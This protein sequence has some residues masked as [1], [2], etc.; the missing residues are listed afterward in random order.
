[1]YSVAMKHILILLLFSTFAF[2]KESV[3]RIEPENPSSLVNEERPN[4]NPLI[5]LVGLPVMTNQEQAIIDAEKRRLEKMEAKERAKE[6]KKLQRMAN[7]KNGGKEPP[8]ETLG[9]SGKK[10][11]K[12]KR[13]VTLGKIATEVYGNPAYATLVSV[14]NKKPANRLF[15][16]EKLK[17]PSPYKIYTALAG[18]KVWEKYPYAI[19]DCLLVHERFKKLEPIIL[20]ESKTKEGFS[21]V[22]KE[23]LDDMIW[24]VDQ[25]KRDFFQKVDGVDEFPTSATTQLHS[26]YT[27]LKSIRR[28]NLGTKNLRLQRVH[29]YLINGYSYALAWGRDGFKTPK[30]K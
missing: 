30:D 20:K 5:S 12:I 11:Y 29:I 25:I 22:T 28:G 2:S 10:K 15:L 27:N 18:K 4:S 17:T 8:L 26:A 9:Y 23:A 7:R 24:N 13:G 19:R 21:D 3:L 14:F 6:E 16:G 1:M